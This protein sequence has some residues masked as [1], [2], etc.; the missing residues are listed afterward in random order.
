MNTK[1][2]HFGWSLTGGWT[3]HDL[4]YLL[5]VNGMSIIPFRGLYKKKNDKEYILRLID[6]NSLPP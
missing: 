3:V 5:M 4:I 1:F 2:L 6:S